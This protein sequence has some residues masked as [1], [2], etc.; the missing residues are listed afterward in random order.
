MKENVCLTDGSV[1]TE[2][3]REIQKDGQQKDYVVLTLDERKKGFIR[4]YRESYVHLTCGW[5]T[6]MNKTIAETYARNPQFYTG[7]FCI[8]CRNHFPLSEFV[9]QG[10]DEIVG[11]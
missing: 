4:P 9:W 10:T 5:N 1:A 8:R 7:T 11:S 6:K 2:N 3:H